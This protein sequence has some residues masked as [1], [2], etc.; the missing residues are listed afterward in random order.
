MAWLDLAGVGTLSDVPD[1]PD[2]P[3]KCGRRSRDFLAFH[4]PPPRRTHL[5]LVAPDA[6]LTHHIVKTRPVV[7][8]QAVTSRAV[9]RQ[10][11]LRTAGA[12]LTRAG[13]KAMS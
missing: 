9:L 2:I 10:S 12:E 4:Q 5:R 7:W 8:R 3:Y 1:I 13:W 6:Q 11:T